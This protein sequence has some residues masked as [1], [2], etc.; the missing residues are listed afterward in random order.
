MIDPGIV[1]LFWIALD[2]IIGII[3]LASVFFSCTVTISLTI[4]VIS[5][6][7]AKIIDW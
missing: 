4:R 5:K 3:L 6:V 7:V 2:I 1:A